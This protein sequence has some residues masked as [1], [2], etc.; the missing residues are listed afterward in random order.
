MISVR[1]DTEGP[2]FWQD[3]KLTQEI[4]SYTLKISVMYTALLS[5][6]WKASN[7]IQW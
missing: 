5:E 2:D 3:V 7:V 1:A 6:R 4:L